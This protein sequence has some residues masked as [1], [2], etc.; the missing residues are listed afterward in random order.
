[1]TTEITFGETV[2]QARTKGRVTLRDLAEVLDVS[3]PYL[4]DVERGRRNPFPWCPVLYRDLAETIGVDKEELKTLA[5][6][7]RHEE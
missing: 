5:K 4:S 7:E 6:S 1:M 2:R 3:I